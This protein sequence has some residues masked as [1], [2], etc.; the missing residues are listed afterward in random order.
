MLA[1]TCTRLQA[2]R[3]S[4]GIVRKGL[5]MSDHHVWK[6]ECN[7]WQGST[8]HRPRRREIK[9]E[10]RTVNGK[11][12]DQKV[13]AHP[14]PVHRSTKQRV[15]RRSLSRCGERRRRSG[16]RMWPPGVPSHGVGQPW[17]AQGSSES[18]GPH[19]RTLLLATHAFCGRR[20]YSGKNTRL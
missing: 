6:P 16:M 2:D 8:I 4:C 12:R 11:P 20:G 19:S 9:S 13:R 14:M 10:E 3:A 7:E 18:P 5:R 15:L 17:G 1:S